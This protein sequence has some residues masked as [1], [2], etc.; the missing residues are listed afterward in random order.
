MRR[1]R[2]VKII[3]TLGPASATPEQIEKLFLAGADV[4]RINMSH[5]SHELLRQYHGIIRKIE[6]RI[7]RPICILAD[8]QGPK[9]RIG[10]FADKEVM[11]KAGDVFVLDSDTTP[12]DATRVYL[13]HPEIFAAIKIPVV[14]KP[15]LSSDSGNF[16]VF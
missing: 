16:S 9:L 3:A 1:N 12:G 2:K 7:G 14:Q 10:T 13:P 4:F 6:A 11:L 5:T 15:N 8:L